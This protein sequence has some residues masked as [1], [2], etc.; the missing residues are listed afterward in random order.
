MY[1]GEGRFYHERMG[2][3]IKVAQ[4]LEVKQISD[5]L[6]MGGEE[7]VNIHEK[8]PDDEMEETC[9]QGEYEGPLQI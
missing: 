5:G 1:L 6:E 2:E 7:E 4:D 3:F 9:N 8:I